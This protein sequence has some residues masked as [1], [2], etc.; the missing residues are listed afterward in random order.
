VEFFI[1]NFRLFACSETLTALR[2][3]GN[4]VRPSLIKKIRGSGN[5]VRKLE[6]VE[7]K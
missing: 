6:F 5:E 3:V 1:K 2:V 4:D 7:M